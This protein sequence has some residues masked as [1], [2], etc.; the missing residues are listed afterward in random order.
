MIYPTLKE[1]TFFK[2]NGYLLKHNMLTEQQVR[3]PLEVIWEHLNCDRKSSVTRPNYG[4]VNPP[5]AGHPTILFTLYESL[6]FEIAEKLIEKG[7]LS[8]NGRPSPLLIVPN[9]Q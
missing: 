5:V 1:K 2:K 6:T 9:Q 3:K 4:P 8:R 7:P